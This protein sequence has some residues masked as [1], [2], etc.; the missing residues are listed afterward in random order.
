VLIGLLQVCAAG[1]DVR[2]LVSRAQTV[3]ERLASLGSQARDRF[4]PLAREVV[5]GQLGSQLRRQEMLLERH[6]GR[7][8]FWERDVRSSMESVRSSIADSPFVAIG[9]LPKAWSVPASIDL[10]REVARLY[11]GLLQ[12]WDTMVHTGDVLRSEGLDLAR[13]V[14]AH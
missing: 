4:E 13:T 12:S 2:D 3:G 9:D 5:L 7:P 11:G 6:S 8:A 10:L 1:V 14:S